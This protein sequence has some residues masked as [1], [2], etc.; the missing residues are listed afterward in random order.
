MIQQNPV[1][2]PLLRR[3]FIRVLDIPLEQ[4]E[5]IVEPMDSHRQNIQV[6][7]VLALHELGMDQASD[8]F[9]CLDF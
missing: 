4:L 7:K 9:D 5:L 6:P 3:W 8:L 2:H 1:L